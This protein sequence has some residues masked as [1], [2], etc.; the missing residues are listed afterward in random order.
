LI[1]QRI[2]KTKTTTFIQITMKLILNFLPLFLLGMVKA[3]VASVKPSSLRNAK[4]NKESHTTDHARNVELQESIYPDTRSI[5]ERKLVDPVTV[6]GLIGA[7]VE[8]G[9]AIA[10]LILGETEKNGNADGFQRGSLVASFAE[11]LFYEIYNYAPDA[12]R[13]VVVVLSNLEYEINFAEGGYIGSATIAGWGYSVYAVNNG[14]IR[15][16]GGRGFENWTVVG[17]QTQN[18][19]IISF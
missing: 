2:D 15:N 17:Y 16:D 6:A 7:G 11:Q 12:H 18:D 14:W 8:A 4:N 1:N 13:T 3:S 5:I 19:N 9:T 10:G